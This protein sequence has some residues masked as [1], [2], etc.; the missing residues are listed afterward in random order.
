MTTNNSSHGS[1][2]TNGTNDEDESLVA[3]PNSIE[4]ESEMFQVQVR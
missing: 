3:F 2:T 1:E 4:I